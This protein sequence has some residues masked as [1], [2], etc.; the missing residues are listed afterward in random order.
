MLL[1]SLAW[2]IGPVIAVILGAMLFYL[3][4]ATGPAVIVTWLIAP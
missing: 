3:Y 4:H 1:G 2:I